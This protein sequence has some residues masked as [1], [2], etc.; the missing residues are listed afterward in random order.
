MGDLFENSSAK[1]LVHTVC[2]L[3][4]PYFRKK[5]REINE[6]KTWPCFWKIFVKSDFYYCMQCWNYGNSLLHLHMYISA[7]FW[8]NFR[9]NNGFTKEVTKELI[10][11]NIFFIETVFCFC[12]ML[13]RNFR[14][15]NVLKLVIFHEINIHLLLVLKLLSRNFFK[16]WCQ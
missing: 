4:S 12:N 16:K 14:Q 13:S 6:F 2:G 9:E 10:S 11:R 7:L 5:L 3:S 8:Q 1:R 15:M